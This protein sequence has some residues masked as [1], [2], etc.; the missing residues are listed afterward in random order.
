MYCCKYCNYS[1]NIKCNYLKH[2]KT[3]KHDRNEKKYLAVYQKN[4]KIVSK[5]EKEYKI[6]LPKFTC[7]Y[8]EKSFTRK[9]NLKRHLKGRCK[10]ILNN[11]ALFTLIDYIYKN[12]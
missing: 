4:V 3:K 8:C 2:L 12:N 11:K 9:D 10:K 7:E 1:T 6:Y 5:S